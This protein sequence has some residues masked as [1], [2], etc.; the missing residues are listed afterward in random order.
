VIPATAHA[1]F[2][3]RFNDC[4]TGAGLRRWLDER[5]AAIGGDYTLEAKISGE[6]FLVGEG[7]LS[8]A[9]AAAIQDVTGRTPEFSTTGG[10][11][12][13][14]FIQACCPL[15]EFGLVG[16][17]MHQADERVDLADLAALTEIYRRFLD[18]YFG[19]APDASG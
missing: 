15:A 6:S 1:V 16:R 2:N 9:L 5:L 10:T 7:T 4:W 17:T 8:H 3:I 19:P 12:D 18:R 11:S 13:A 14:R